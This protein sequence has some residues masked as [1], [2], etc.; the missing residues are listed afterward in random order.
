MYN[1]NEIFCLN[2]WHEDIVL[3]YLSDVQDIID[4]STADDDDY[5]AFLD[6]LTQ[7]IM[8]HNENGEDSYLDTIFR[9]EW[10]YAL[11]NMVYWA[12]LGYLAVI[13]KDEGQINI[14]VTKLAKRLT[15][16]ND[17]IGKMVLIN[18]FID[19]DKTILN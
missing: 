19:G 6:V 18:P 13:P 5:E 3:D 2:R 17:R 14:I 1:E 8:V 11:P 16:V 4:M 15:K 12:A 7:I 9:S 10:L